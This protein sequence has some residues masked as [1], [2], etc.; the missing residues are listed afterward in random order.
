M[1]TKNKE[2]ILS[3]AKY[4]LK[5]V[6]SK[7]NCKCAELFFLKNKYINIDVEENSVKHSEIGED[8]GVSIRMIDNRGSLGFAI[9]NILTRK[10]VEKMIKNAYNLMRNGTEDPDFKDLPQKESKYP[11]VKGL[12]DA[13]IKNIELENSL[14][15]VKEMI[16]ICEKDDFAVSQ[17]ANFSASYSKVFI[18]N[19]N[20]L[21]AIKANT[22]CTVVST[23]IVKDKITKD[24]STGYD[25]QSERSLN[26]INAEEIAKNAL[27]Y[28]KLNL[29]RI[30]IKSMVCPII[31]T[32]NGVIDFILSPISSAVN[33]E[34][35]QY[36]RTFLVGY[37][38]EFIGSE[39]L[40]IEDN[41]LIDGAAGSA[42]FDG[43][44]IPCTKKEII[45]K[46]KFERL[47]H[48]S[49]TAGKDGVQSTGN[50]SRSSYNVLPSIG[51]SN[52]ILKPGTTNKDEIITDISEGI[53]LD[54]T[55][56]S[57]NIATGDF[58]GLILR[59]NLIKKGEIKEPL[60]ETMF[61][62]NLL[63]LLKNIS[64][65]SKEFKIYGAYRAP[66]VKIDN[67]KIIGAA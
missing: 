3:L 51:T 48:N 56:D 9:T 18:F 50:A 26:K 27:N 60:N 58:S 67:I 37:L 4:G 5:L 21:E 63:D 16:K 32:P 31:L 55:G 49:Y 59:G 11:D 57:P 17:S 40:T 24:I 28:A 65:I 41:G 30:K 66:Y 6:E 23:I 45:S 36:K 12:Y 22:M 43:E 47:L 29:N 46:G 52:F 10:N 19:T 35:Y 13:E 34:A 14:K 20:G 44:G 15:Y 62:V 8:S 54:S 25:W 2:D 38:N 7:F 1:N 61:A 33:A 64:L 42:I 39:I 53:L